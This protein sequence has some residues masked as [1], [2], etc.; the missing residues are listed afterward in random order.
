MNVLLIPIYG[1]LLDNRLIEESYREE[2]MEK[3][4]RLSVLENEID[5]KENRV[6]RRPRTEKLSREDSGLYRVDE[7]EEEAMAKG[8]RKSYSHKEGYHYRTLPRQKVR[9]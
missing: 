8:T 6:R 9:T 5:D 1:L 7:T 2:M 3:E 4:R